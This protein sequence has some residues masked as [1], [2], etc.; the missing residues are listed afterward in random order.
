MEDGVALVHYVR[1]EP[2]LSGL[3]NAIQEGCSRRED[4][5]NTSYY[6]ANNGNKLTS[7]YII[8]YNYTLSWAIG[9]HQTND[10][11]VESIERARVYVKGEQDVSSHFI[12]K[13]DVGLPFRFTGSGCRQFHCSTVCCDADG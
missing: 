4:V 5:C 8:V 7:V 6:Q 1:G 12:D 10:A 9:S 13:P 11:L 3:S 2:R